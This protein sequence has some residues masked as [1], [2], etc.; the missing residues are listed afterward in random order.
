MVH[1]RKLAKLGLLVSQQHGLAA[2]SEIHLLG[3]LTDSRLSH[4]HCEYVLGATRGGG[5]GF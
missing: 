1:P 4:L 2:V 3:A 5:T